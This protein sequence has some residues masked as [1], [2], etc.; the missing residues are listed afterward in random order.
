MQ[1]KSAYETLST[2]L[3]PGYGIIQI[4]DPYGITAQRHL[5]TL[6]TLPKS[7]LDRGVIRPHTLPLPPATRCSLLAL[8]GPVQRREEGMVATEHDPVTSTGRNRRSK[9]DL[10]VDHSIQVYIRFQD[11]PDRLPRLGASN[12]LLLLLLCHQ[13]RVVSDA[14]LDPSRQEGQRA[15]TVGHDDCEVLDNVK[16]S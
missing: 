16:Y 14:A 2:Q 3:P 9:A 15:T 7:A 8:R 10:A 5:L 12:L 1:G 11:L 13:H 4:Q 6:T